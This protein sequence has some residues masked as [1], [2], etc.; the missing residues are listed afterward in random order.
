MAAMPSTK[1]Q[2]TAESWTAIA[3]AGEVRAVADLPC[4]AAVT[5]TG[6]A[7][8]DPD[9]AEQVNAKEP[10]HMLLVGAERLYIRGAGRVAV[11]AEAAL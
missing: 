11:R 7:P 9:V 2:L 1:K 4:L 5:I 10:I 8:T 3:S 6:A